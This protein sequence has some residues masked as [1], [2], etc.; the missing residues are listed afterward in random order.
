MKDGFDNSV[1]S[2]VFDDGPVCVFM[3]E[4]ITGEWPVVKV[5]RNIEALTGWPDQDF[6]S[7]DK[8]YADLIHQDDLARI[9]AEE[10]HW[11]ANN[12]TEI[13]NMNYRIVNKSGV[14]RHVSEY[15]QSVFDQNGVITHLVGY[16]LD[17]TDHWL[18][19]QDKKAAEAAARAKSEF[20]ANMSHEIRTP[21]NGVMGMAELLLRTD[22]D[23]KQKTF[24]ETIVKSGGSLLTIINDI[25][26]FSK[27]DAGQMALDVAP[28]EL[29]DAIDQVAILI[30]S[31]AAEKDLELAVRVDPELPGMFVGDVGRLRQIITN[32]VGNAVKFTAQG[33][34]FINVNGETDTEGNTA[35][36]FRIEDTGIGIPKEKRDKIFEKF[37]QV[38]GSATREH[39]GTGLG[40]AIASALVKLMDGEIGVEPGETAGSVFWFTI[41]LPVHGETR[42][43][44]RAPL[45]VTGARILIVDDNEVNRSILIEQMQAWQLESVATSSGPEA[46]AVMRFAADQDIVFDALILD[47]QMPH[48]SGEDVAVAMQADS[49]LKDIPVIM[50]T[51]VDLTEEG[52]TFSSLGVAGHLVKPARSSLLFDTIIGVLHQRSENTEPGASRAPDTAGE[53]LRAK[54]TIQTVI[55]KSADAN[56]ALN[57][58]AATRPEPRVRVMPQAK[59][60]PAPTPMPGAPQQVS[61]APTIRVGPPAR[62]TPGETPATDAAPAV[63]NNGIDV[64]VAEDNEV[65]QIVF[66]EILKGAGFTYRIANNGE[67]AVEM[68]AIHRPRVI[69]MDVSMPI[70]NGLEATAEIRQREAEAGGRTPVIGVTAHAIEGDMEKCIEAGMDDYLSKPVSPNR[71]TEKIEKWISGEASAAKTA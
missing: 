26:D 46:L 45:D 42:K 12:N 65:N 7:G 69:C 8:N 38:D 64:L 43:R 41:P 60:D 31:G 57:T 63:A 6:L 67:E 5:T 59:A 32:L 28:F 61:G 25:L 51:S 44:Q 48:M 23:A 13:V 9:E 62:Q 34:V 33:H 36:S 52:Q 20:L 39:E 14:A 3:W 66:S 50:L 54:G 47:Y 16:I 27:V 24:A 18:T 2:E 70:L 71:L 11:K 10:E 21:M 15:T 1:W 37:S 17:V 40:L 29:R 4:N 19:V 55:R 58:N 49:R 53:P 68:H 35:L 56:P 22:L 30:S